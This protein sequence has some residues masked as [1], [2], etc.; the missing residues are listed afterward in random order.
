MTQDAMEPMKRFLNAT[1]D[2]ERNAAQAD[3]EIAAAEVERRFSYRAELRRQWRA[4]N[5]QVQK[6]FGA[7]PMSWQQWLSYLDETEAESAEA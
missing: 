7:K 1:T 3:A 6:Q 4:D 5:E 2:E